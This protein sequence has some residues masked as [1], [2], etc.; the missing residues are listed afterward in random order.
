LSMH[1]KLLHKVVKHD[2]LNDIWY[3]REGWHH[4]DQKCGNLMW[5]D[6]DTSRVIATTVQHFLI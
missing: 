5:Y 3:K 4:H 2:L 6:Q 1:L